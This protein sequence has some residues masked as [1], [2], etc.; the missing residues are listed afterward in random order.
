MAVPKRHVSK[1]RRDKRRGSS[2]TLEA[3]AIVKC[4]HCG[5]YT[6]PHKVCASCGWYDG[7]QVVA[8]EED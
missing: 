2:W 1:T 3:P 4:A 7:K 6:A 8:T 5:S